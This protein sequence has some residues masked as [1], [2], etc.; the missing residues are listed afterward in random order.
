VLARGTLDVVRH[1]AGKRP[2]AVP[3]TTEFRHFLP[4]SRGTANKCTDLKKR[5][6][7]HRTFSNRQFS[8]PHI[9]H[10]MLRW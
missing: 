6:K 8:A 4:I 9:Q 3:E 7:F 2:R 1:L 10:I 5:K